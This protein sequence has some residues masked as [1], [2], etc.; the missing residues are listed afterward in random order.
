MASI[1]R[2]SV[3]W[4]PVAGRWTRISIMGSQLDEDLIKVKRNG[5]NDKR[6]V[7]LLIP[8]TSSSEFY[9]NTMKM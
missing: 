9:S 7:I 6:T 5:D 1:I 3:Q 8:G 4:V 2:R